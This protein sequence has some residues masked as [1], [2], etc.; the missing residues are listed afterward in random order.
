[1]NSILK[2]YLTKNKINY[3]QFGK[4]IGISR[5]AC[6][7]I[8]LGIIKKPNIDTALKIEQ[9]TNGEVSVQKLAKGE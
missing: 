5:D 3:S 2:E 9:A 1:M 6:R 7:K 4:K 8:A